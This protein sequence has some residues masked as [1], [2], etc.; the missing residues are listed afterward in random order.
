MREESERVQWKSDIA[1]KTVHENF[2]SGGLN[3]PPQKTEPKANETTQKLKQPS[4]N[5]LVLT[6][7]AS[8]PQVQPQSPPKQ[9]I[10]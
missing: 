8:K 6:V 4:E 1:I 7:F 2:K 3:S 10:L 5:E 9:H